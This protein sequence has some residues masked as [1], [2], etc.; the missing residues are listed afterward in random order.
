MYSAVATSG[1]IGGQAA[2]QQPGDLVAS[3]RTLRMTS[4][5]WALVALELLDRVVR[6]PAVAHG[7]AHHVPQ[8]AECACRGL[9]R[10]SALT[11][12]IEEVGH[13]GHT[14]LADQPTSR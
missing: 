11:Q 12:A 14:D 7:E 5:S 2:L 8:G 3:Q 4:R 9:L 1:A 6:D 13:V 10:A